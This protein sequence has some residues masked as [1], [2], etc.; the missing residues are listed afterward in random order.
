MLCG[1][2]F[3]TIYEWR[4]SNPEKV[5]DGYIKDFSA[6]IYMFSENYRS[7]KTLAQ[8]TFGYLQNT[9]PQWVGK[10]CPESLTINSEKQGEP[11]SCYAF[12]NREEE[13]WKIYKYLQATKGK[14]NNACVIA[15][16]NKYIAELYR[17]F[18]KFNNQTEEEELRFF[19]VEENF[20]F[21]K[22]PVIKDIL[23]VLRLLI[24]QADRSSLERLTEKYVK[25][26]GVK[27]IESLRGYNQIG[28]SILSFIHPQTHLYGDCYYHLIEGYNTDNIVI[29]D[30]ETTGLDLA[31]DE[32][33][34]LSAIKLS[35]SGE[36]LDTLDLMIEP[37]V[38][39]SQAAYETHGFD[40]QFIRE[41]GGIT[42][43]EALQ[44]F[45]DFTRGCVL[46]GHNNL[47]Y[48]KPL[49]ERQLKENGLPPLNI[50]AEY[51]T[52]VIAK[53]F[54]GYLENFKLDTL[55]KN[56]NV[57][58]ECAH[59]ALGDITATGQCLIAMLQEKI[60]PTAAERRAILSKYK[61]RFAKIYAFI[62]EMRLRLQNGEELAGHIIDRLNLKKL[63]PTNG[64]LTAMRDIMETLKPVEDM[65]SFLKEFLKDAALSNSQMDVLIQKLNRI[66]I[67]TIHQSKGC[68]FDTVILAG[69]DDS[70]FPTHAA[71]QSG[72]ED[73]ERKVFYVAITRAKEKLILTRA[74][75]NG[76]HEL[77]ETPYFWMLPEEYIQTNYA[78]RTGN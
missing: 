75:R 44:R 47:C 16:S 29:Y 55:C 59:N 57:I 21:Y 18:E 54:Y 20:N 65:E 77:N 30:T 24:N 15:R 31:K 48:D 41:N 37:T 69:A 11:I 53:Q 71:K 78:W 60:L 63:Y 56:F 36:I 25:M 1:D 32:I 64:D 61:E 17:Y 23:A 67:I 51:D 2:F 70:N 5:L 45:S 3:Q 39:I 76:R 19:T 7:T 74:M 26:V 22:K 46:V 73:E 43:L 68:E 33:V 58:N 35:R 34:Q 38:E 42:A 13:A 4:G 66:P 50:L 52:L 6:K 49:V 72:K 62:E 40:L 27:T 8:A 14:T 9:Y 12:S 10:Y 28:V